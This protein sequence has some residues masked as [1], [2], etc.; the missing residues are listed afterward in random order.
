MLSK[1]TK[2]NLAIK[3][4]VRKRIRTRQ[5]THLPKTAAKER[6]GNKKP[7]KAKERT[8]DPKRIIPVEVAVRNRIENSRGNQKSVKSKKRYLPVE[9]SIRDRIGTRQRCHLTKT[10]AKERR[11]KEKQ[12]TADKRNNPVEAAVMD[13]GGNKRLKRKPVKE[14]KPFY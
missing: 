11:R 7:A 10:A 8:N 5:R 9:V 2:R 1:E 13:R 3:L 12:A 14:K 4:D 6:T